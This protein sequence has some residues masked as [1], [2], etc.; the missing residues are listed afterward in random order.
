MTIL[1]LY[2]DGGFHDLSAYVKRNTTTQYSS[3]ADRMFTNFEYVALA[4]STDARYL[5]GLIKTAIYKA[6][7]NLAGAWLVRK[8]D[9]E[10]KRY[11]MIYGGSVEQANDDDW[12]RYIVSTEHSAEAETTADTEAVTVPLLTDGTADLGLI[13]RGDR[14]G[15]VRDLTIQ[16]LNAGVRLDQVWIGIKPDVSS[17]TFDPNIDFP[18]ALSQDGNDKSIDTVLTASFTPNMVEVNFTQTENMLHRFEAKFGWAW[19]S[20]TAFWNATALSF[21]DSYPGRYRLV[22]EWNGSTINSA[23]LVQTYAGYAGNYGIIGTTYLQAKTA[24]ENHV[25]E[26]GIFEMPAGVPL[27]HFSIRVAVARIAGS[28]LLRFGSGRIIPQDH[29]VTFGNDEMGIRKGPPET[30]GHVLT[31]WNG[32]HS[33]YAR[34]EYD[35]VAPPFEAVNWR[36]PLGGCV[37]MHANQRDSSLTGGGVMTEADAVKLTFDWKPRYGLHTYLAQVSGTLGL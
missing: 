24:D 32:S 30:I 5:I 10:E 7:N 4:S 22:I 12:A 3:S 36:R 9:G 25:I 19:G 18:T 27:D 33:V 14:P 1:G 11:Y 6:E 26:L 29:A 31:A 2:Y 15:R 35:S 34:G 20:Q 21:P 28:G 16:S 17:A 37:V 13:A 23:F 8:E